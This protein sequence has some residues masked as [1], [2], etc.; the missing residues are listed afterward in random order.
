M[1]V[2]LKGQVSHPNIKLNII[3]NIERGVLPQVKSIVIHRTAG[4]TA[5]ST[6]NTWKIKKSGAH[7]LIGK[8][9]AIYQTAGLNKQCWHMGLVMSRCR[10][11]NAC[12]DNDIKVIKGF[13][14]GPGTWKSRY[15]KV[16]SHEKKKNYPE[17]YPMNS[18]SVG[19]ELV[20][21]YLGVGDKG[22]FESPTKE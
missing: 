17:R 12:T 4:N 20:G 11:E 10:L 22:P 9:G 2:I 16:L 3:S 19:V 1:L 8:D 14:K 13:L 18:D 21:L 7:F 15:Q 6:L 5:G